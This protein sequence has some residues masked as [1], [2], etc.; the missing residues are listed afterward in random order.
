M[1]ET[2]ISK[3]CYKCK[4][5]K[6]LSE[7]PAHRNRHDGHCA[8][9][10]ICMNKYNKVYVHTKEGKAARKRYTQSKKGKIVHAKGSP[11]YRRLYP[12]KYKAATALGTAVRNK[13]LPNAKSLQCSSCTEPAIEYHHLKGYAPKHRLNVIPVCGSCHKIIHVIQS[14]NNNTQS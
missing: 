12:E 14:E 9:C 13:T 6:S 11:R 7:F 2:I 10:K 8:E 3:R 5:I 1:A 4:Q